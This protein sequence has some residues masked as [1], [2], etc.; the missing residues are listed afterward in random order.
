MSSM[1]VFFFAYHL[2]NSTFQIDLIKNSFMSGSAKILQGHGLDALNNCRYRQHG[3]PYRE[4]R[5]FLI[6]R[7]S[8][9]YPEP[10]MTLG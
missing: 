5:Q 9:P 7:G 2:S 3:R 1:V 10:F 4:R 8:E 6:I